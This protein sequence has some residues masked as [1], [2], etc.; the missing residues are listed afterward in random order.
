MPVFEPLVILVL[1]LLNGLLAMSEIALVSSR[2]ARLRRLADEHHRGARAA[3]ALLAQPT[4]FLSTVQI[5]ITLVGIVA[6]AYGGVTIGERL[7]AWLNQYPAIAPHGT[8]IGVGLVVVAVSWLSLIFGELVPKRIALHD[9]ERVS[10]LVAPLMTLLARLAAP[11]VWVLEISTESVLALLRLRGSGRAPIS[12]DEVKALVA[13]GARAGIFLPKEREMIEA[14]LRLAD[15]PVRV[16]MTHRTDIVWVD[17]RDGLRE[18]AERLGALEHARYP[19]CDASIDR[20]VGVVHAKRLLHRLLNGAA[21]AVEAAMVPALI[22]PEWMPALEVLD[23]F[24]ATG[25]HMAI[26]TDA[27]VT[28]GLVTP[29]DIL[30]SIAGEL[31]ERGEEPEPP[32]VQRDDGCWLVDGYLPIDELED[33]T[34]LRGLRGTRGDADY[35]T[36][37]GLVLHALGELPQAGQHVELAGARFEVVDMD[38]TRIDKVLISPRSEPPGDPAQ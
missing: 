34:G 36:V 3:L 24:R 18:L 6:G 32:I 10:T 9:P 35:V 20:P 11:I 1:V 19:V 33:R 14:V 7:G 23:R 31:P 16:I 27:G 4:R 5:G 28:V 30:E 12:E 38:G 37:A 8:A 26:V 13:E 2:R 21:P 15:R 17:R 29:N 22:V 25:V